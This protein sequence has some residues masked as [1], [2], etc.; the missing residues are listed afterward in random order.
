M[1]INLD[2]ILTISARDWCESE[3]RNLKDYKLI[4]VHA[5]GNIEIGWFFETYSG[6]DKKSPKSQLSKRCPKE[7]VVVTDYISTISRSDRC[8]AVMFYE[9]NG[10][11]LIPR[12]NLGKKD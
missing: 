1:A 9:A 6:D 5:L 4:G 2:K 10:I 7:A 11:A 8:D 3:G 12:E